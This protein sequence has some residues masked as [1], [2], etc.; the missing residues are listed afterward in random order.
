MIRSLRPLVAVGAA[1]LAVVT[2]SAALA[3]AAP[4]T[5]EQVAQ[6]YLTAV[7][8]TNWIAAAQLMHPS[9][10]AQF[11]DMF[12]PV[13]QC[14]GQE[15]AQ[16]REALF[17]LHSLA[18]ATR[19][20]DTV[21]MASLLRFGTT[22]REGLADVLRTAQMQVIGHVPE[23][24]DTVHVLTRLTFALDSIRVSQ[25]EVISFRR[26][27]ATW[28]TLLKADISAMGAMLRRLCSAGS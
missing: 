15:V 13:L 8:D 28:R 21:L 19:V 23:G 27:G 9:A 5:P 7:R 4:E 3:Q 14:E 16:A 20:S 24:A 25:V 10:L 11:H 12:R 1:F 6:Q 22:R 26:F 18:E 17:G 2:A